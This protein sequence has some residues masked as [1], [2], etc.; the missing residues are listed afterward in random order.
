MTELPVDW[1]NSRLY[2]N[3]DKA[4]RSAVKLNKFY[5]QQLQHY[6]F[7]LAEVYT[8]Y[9][10]Y[11]LFLSAFDN[12]QVKQRLNFVANSL[13]SAIDYQDQFY[14]SPATLSRACA[15]LSAT[16]DTLLLYA[17]S[18]KDVPCQHKL[19]HLKQRLIDDHE[20]TGITEEANQHKRAALRKASG[21]I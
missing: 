21:E 3:K 12:Q 14:N 19:K 20:R 18:R 10:E 16:L 1:G 6:N 11:W 4:K 9:R 7:L 8:A 13:D 17:T 5:Q 2:K 15:D